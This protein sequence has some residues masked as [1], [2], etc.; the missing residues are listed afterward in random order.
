[1][2]HYFGARAGLVTAIHDFVS[3]HNSDV[4]ARAGKLA[5]PA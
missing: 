5:Q 1:L 2:S 3:T 4:D